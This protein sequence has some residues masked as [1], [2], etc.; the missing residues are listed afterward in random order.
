KLTN[1]GREMARLPIA[2]TVSRM[3]LQAQK[4]GAL[5]EV[6]IIA[7]AISIQDPR[8]RPLDQQQQADQEHRKFIHKGSDFLT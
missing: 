3:V 1:L 5:R 2:P 6:L 7:S 4:E 8:V